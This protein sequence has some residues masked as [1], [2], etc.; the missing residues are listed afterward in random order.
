MSLISSKKK[1]K[2]TNQISLKTNV[3]ILLYRTIFSRGTLR[4][5][6]EQAVRQGNIH[7]D[8]GVRTDEETDQ[9]CDQ[10]VHQR[11][12]NADDCGGQQRFDQ[13]N[14]PDAS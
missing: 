10:E 12:K 1:G 13:E 6:D 9:C 3:H 11:R 4:Y 8:G 2:C 14:Y 7:F 5:T